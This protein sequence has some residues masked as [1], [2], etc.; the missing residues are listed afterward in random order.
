MI[1]K[2]ILFVILALSVT[3]V[4]SQS[5]PCCKNKSGNGK[6][7]CKLGQSET[8]SNGKQ[9]SASDG[10]ELASSE[11]VQCSK[12]IQQKCNNKSNCSNRT[13]IPWWMF[14]KKKNDCCNAK[15]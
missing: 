5:K 4:F 9:A 2:N 1:K 8:E 3:L 14:W 11:L 13:N 10:P 15:S 7:A 6:V 12:G